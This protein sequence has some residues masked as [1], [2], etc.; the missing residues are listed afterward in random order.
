M[1]KGIRRIHAMDELRGLLILL[2]V[3]H[4][5]LYTL[6][7][8]FDVEWARTVE[9]VV[10]YPIQSLGA[11]LFILL[12]GIS[13]HLSHN[14]WKRGGLL[15]LVAV[16]LSTVLWVVMPDQMI[17][18]G[19]LHCLA[20]C[21]LLFALC[22][23]LL[24]HVPP[25]LGL[26]VCAVGLLNTWWLPPGEGGFFGI[27][28][29]YGVHLPAS[30][31]QT[32]WL[33]PLGLGAGEGADYFPLLPWIFV[34]LAG[35]ILGVWARQGRFPEFLYKSRVRWLSWCGRHTLIIYIL[36]QPVIYGICWLLFR[37][38]GVTT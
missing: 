27:P 32:P 13:C 26:I 36:H 14:N 34:F 35:T 29:L 25:W 21:I 33:Y 30:V 11:G 7:H 3:C 18:F 23:P 37:V 6:G 28:G 12:C 24:N 4:H 38:C 10:V 2:M 17:W 1:D 31:V 16:G 5:A 22:R 20:V 8:L 9:R 19:I 15:A